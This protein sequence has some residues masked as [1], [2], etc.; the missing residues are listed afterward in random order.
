MLIILPL[1]LI[2]V[3]ILA[4]RVFLILN[5]SLWCLTSCDVVNFEINKKQYSSLSDYI[6]DAP[7]N[8]ISVNYTYV[9]NG[10]KM[11]SNR[12]SLDL[13]ARGYRPVEL[14]HDKFIEKLKNKNCNVYYFKYWP[15]L[16]VLDKKPYHVAS[17]LAFLFIYIFILLGSYLIVLWIS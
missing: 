13:V 9:I 1:I 14:D 3:I 2:P 5:K 15:K 8:Y 11:C 17:N 4:I 7:N 6:D 10:K 16:A 12:M